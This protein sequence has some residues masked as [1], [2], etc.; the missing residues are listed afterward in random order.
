MTPAHALAHHLPLAVF[1]FDGYGCLRLIRD[2]PVGPHTVE[3]HLVKPF[4]A[5]DINVLEW[6]VFST[7]EHNYRTTVGTPVLA[8][9]D[10]RL[11]RDDRRRQAQCVQAYNDQAHDLL[12]CMKLA[13]RRHGLGFFVSLRLNHCTLSDRPWPCP[14]RTFGQ[15]N[16]TRKDFSDPAF[17]DY[18]L[19][20]LDE[21]AQRQPDA[22]TLDF[23]RKAPFFPP[24]V[25]ARTRFEAADRF[26]G[27]ARQLVDRHSQGRDQP[28]LLAARVA[29]DPALGEP[30]G[31]RPFH[32]MRQ[33]WLDLVIPATHNHQPDALDWSA[34]AFIDARAHGPRPCL[35]LPQ[36]WPSP[37]S[38]DNWTAAGRHG[39]DAVS[40]RAQ[41]LLDQQADGIYLFNFRLPQQESFPEVQA[42]PRLLGAHR[43]RA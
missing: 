19:A 20:L 34:Q 5:T 26:V 37:G 25:E 9:A 30:Q 8:D 43:C 1:N 17:Q 36:I 13:A 31:Q 16:G 42:Y 12:D 39:P 35:V 38:Y 7:A 14:G 29:H 6:T 15:G 18:L 21:L 28:L 10:A 32:W 11:G 22:L 4:L 33:G 3:Q 27:A 41:Q 2:L 24:A 40:R 23:E